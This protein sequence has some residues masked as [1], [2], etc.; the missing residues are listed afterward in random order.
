MLVTQLQMDTGIFMFYITDTTCYVVRPQ[1]IHKGFITRQ[2][3]IIY[4][5]KCAK[6]HNTAVAAQ[7]WWSIPI[8]SL[9]PWWQA[10]KIHKL[11]WLLCFVSLNITEPGTHICIS[12]WISNMLSQF[13]ITLSKQTSH[14][15]GANGQ[16]LH[17]LFRYLL[18]ILTKHWYLFLL[19][20]NPTYKHLWCNNMPKTTCFWFPSGKR[21]L[22][23]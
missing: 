9:L 8:N 10:F 20:S 23:S 1:E 3:V 14:I 11:L 12:K 13:G 21:M 5:L 16:L 4:C 22:I 15:H 2:Q 7:K 17:F 18:A 6:D 19:N